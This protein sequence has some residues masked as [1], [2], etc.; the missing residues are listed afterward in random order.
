MNIFYWISFLFVNSWFSVA[1][2]SVF[3]C[4]Y[5][6]KEKKKKNHPLLFYC[7]YFWCLQGQAQTYRGTHNAM[8]LDQ[9]ANMWCLSIKQEKFQEVSVCRFS[10]CEEWRQ[11][12]KENYKK[13]K[14]N[15][16]F[17][18]W[19]YRQQN[20]PTHIKITLIITNDDVE[21]II[22]YRNM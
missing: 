19:E 20:R 5:Q 14:R 7:L 12:Q 15:T 3:E 9:V 4:L 6:Q 2:E 11:P 16:V 10:V 21:V 17:I 13:K 18:L 22:W 8:L 1:S